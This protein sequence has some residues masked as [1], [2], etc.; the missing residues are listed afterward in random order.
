MEMSDQ[1]HAP[2]TLP[3]EN[4]APA[5]IPR[6]H[7]RDGGCAEEINI[8]FSGNPTS[9]F[10]FPARSLVTVLTELPQLYT[11]SGVAGI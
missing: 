11:V 1:T 2:A 5:N 4:E 6:P 10:C 9:F 7:S 3:Q 8:N